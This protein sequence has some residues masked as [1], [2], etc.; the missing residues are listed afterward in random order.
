MLSEHAAEVMHRL[1]ETARIELDERFG[2]LESHPRLYPA[3]VDDRFP[4]CRTFWQPPSYRVFYMV[5]AAG[6]DVYIVA[7][8]E[9]EVEAMD[10]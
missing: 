7:I 4:G 5:S 1:P 3:A 2:R 6:E 8:T 9:E 10:G